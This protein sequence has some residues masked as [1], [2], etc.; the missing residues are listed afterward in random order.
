MNFVKASMIHDTLEIVKQGVQVEKQAQLVLEKDQDPKFQAYR[1]EEKPAK[2]QQKPTSKTTQ[3]EITY[4]ADPI[5]SLD[6]SGVASIEAQ[7]VAETG[8]DQDS[9]TS[10]SEDTQALSLIY[11]IPSTPKKPT[12]I[13]IT[14]VRHL[15]QV[16]ESMKDAVM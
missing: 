6:L 12:H 1:Q 4:L 3:L 13:S 7:F 11:V 15:S 14:E 9:P 16:F 10:K 2:S 8:P 5:N